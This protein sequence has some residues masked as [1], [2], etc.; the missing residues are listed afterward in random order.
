MDH[1]EHPKDDIHE[2]SFGKKRK[3][4]NNE[5]SKEGKRSSD[6]PMDLYEYE[7]LLKRIY[8]SMEE[9]GVDQRR[10]KVSMSSPTAYRDGT[11][12]TVWSNF[13]E[14]CKMFVL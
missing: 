4:I 13:S 3:K 14:T 8:S 5:V 12:K 1:T 11:K 9:S 2:F 7:F 6:P 10:E